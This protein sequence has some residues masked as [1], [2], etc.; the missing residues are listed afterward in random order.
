[1][2][3]TP[4]LYQLK[5]TL[6]GTKPPVWR[7]LVVPDNL[8]LADLHQV[9]QVAM[10]WDS[11]GWD[12]HLHEFNVNGV[13]F[14][15]PTHS[16]GWDGVTDEYQVRLG[17][18]ADQGSRLGYW[19]DFGDD[20]RHRVVVEKVLDGGA[21]PVAASCVAGRM[22]CPPEDCGG[23]W[24][25]EALL[26]VLADPSHPDYEQMAEWAGEIDPETFDREAVN[27]R[28]AGMFAV[29]AGRA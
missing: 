11:V 26:E 4:S 16:E 2:T 15:D 27:A 1:M 13:A 23:V 10:G 6:L 29:M 3:T 8:T 22:A 25:Y 20:W 24:G 7:R 28:L 21:G 14:G 17:E 9:L 5:V 18:V 12:Y 19:Y